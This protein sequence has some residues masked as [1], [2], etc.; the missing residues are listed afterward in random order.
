[1]WLNI[2]AA[3]LSDFPNL[4]HAV[5]KV[6]SPLSFISFFPFSEILACLLLM[7]QVTCIKYLVMTPETQVPFKVIE[8]LF[9]RVRK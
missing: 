3:K 2:T 5:D 7:S 9:R 6:A 8:S 4:S 1:M